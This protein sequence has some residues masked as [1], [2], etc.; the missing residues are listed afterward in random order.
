MSRGPSQSLILKVSPFTTF[1]SQ[2]R[3]AAQ[4]SFSVGECETS[5]GETSKTV[6]CRYIQEVPKE[7]I[8]G[9]SR[10]R[11]SLPWPQM[12]CMTHVPTFSVLGAPH[13]VSWVTV[14]PRVGHLGRVTW[15]S[16]HQE[17]VTFAFSRVSAKCLSRGKEICRNVKRHLKR[18]QKRSHLR[19]LLG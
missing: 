7:V 1:C 11:L 3:Q 4:E 12:Y 13:A 5:S 2:N 6:T 10:C 14:G 19:S 17:T 16:Y 18:S 15:G 8:N 9:V